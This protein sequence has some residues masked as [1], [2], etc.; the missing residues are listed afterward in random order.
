MLVMDTS[1]SDDPSSASILPSRELA[2][3]RMAGLRSGRLAGWS[4][5]SLSLIG[6]ASLLWSADTLPSF[7]RTAPAS[8]AAER[9]I[10]DDRFKRGVLADVLAGIEAEPAPAFSQPELVR[11]K[12]LVRLRLAEEAVAGKGTEKV[13]REV[14]VAEESVKSALTVIPGDSFLWLMLY[15][16]ET[17]RNGFD[18]QNI[19]YLDQ[20]YAMGP[21]EGWISLRRNRL[22][23]AI[24]SMLDDEVRIA[25]IS[26]FAEMVDSDFI[27]D[28]ARNLMGIGW[29]FHDQ[30]LAAL[31]SVD[32]V[33][34]QRLYR[35][36][37]VDGIKLSVPGI[38][39]D[40]RPWR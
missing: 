32:V 8:T 7:W 10:A 25:V 22:G 29:Q 21:H 38:P 17:T 4:R 9:I 35:R 26:E 36:L 40:E 24:L 3:R 31:V 11:A 37:A 34:R 19:H 13:D 20:S 1:N 23:L 6:L 27:E 15:S 28:T 12:A 18:T 39:I 16:V 33:S 5:V 2:S 30:L 14:T